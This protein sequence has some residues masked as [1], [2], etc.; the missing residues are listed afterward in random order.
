[1][2]DR[3]AARAPA[4][5]RVFAVLVA[6]WTGALLLL[7]FAVAPTAFGLL[8]RDVAGQLMGRLFAI[9][10]PIS[11]ALAVLGLVLHRRAQSDVEDVDGGTPAPVRVLTVDVVLLAGVLFCTVA[12]YYGLQPS[13]AAA[14]GG[15]G[16]GLSFG[17]LHGL[18]MAFFAAKALMLATLAWRASAR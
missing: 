4:R 15:A 7:S 8:P 3:A 17:A 12:G 13:M 18:S 16:G 11:C 6:G 2:D 1:M 9:E 10:A 5:Q 14:R